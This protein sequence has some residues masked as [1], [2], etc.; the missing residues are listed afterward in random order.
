[1]M[2]TIRRLLEKAIDN[3]EIDSKAVVK[4]YIVPL[5]NAS[6]TDVANI[7]RDAYREYI[8]NDPMGGGRFEARGFG[9]GAPPA[10][11]LDA[12]GNPRGVTLS[13]GVDDRSNRLILVCTER[14]FDE[15]KKLVDKLD[16]ASVNATTTVDVLQIKGIDPLVMQ[17]A[18]DA[19]QGRRP[20]Q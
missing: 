19:L 20:S 1:D 10:R 14:M 11:N 16:E 7:L 18:I 4:N 2:M 13:I 9:F 12:N 8:N 6:A 5:K 15:I 3:D 17:Q